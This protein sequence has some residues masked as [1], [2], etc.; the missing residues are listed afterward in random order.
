MRQVPG[1]QPDFKGDVTVRS[2][3]NCRY[4]DVFMGRSFS[5]RSA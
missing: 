4:S 2:D 5:A 3:I 1:R